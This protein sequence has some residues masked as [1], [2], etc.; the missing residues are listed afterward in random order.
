M[1]WTRVLLPR[2]RKPDNVMHKVNTTGGLFMCI[3]YVHTLYAHFMCTLYMHYLCAHF[4]CTLYVH[5][6]CALFMCTLYV[7]PLCALFR[8]TVWT[9]LI[10]FRSSFS[11]R[12]FCFRKHSKTRC[13]SSTTQSRCALSGE[14]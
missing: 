8:R 1:L 10:K 11:L 4:M 14:R 13:V 3:L 6:L 12:I 2:H 5:S 9:S 7:H